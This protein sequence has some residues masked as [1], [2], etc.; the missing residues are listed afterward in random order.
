MRW[1]WQ[2]KP[3]APDDA[4]E[5]LAAAVARDPEIRDLT[6]RLEARRRENRFALMIEEALRTHR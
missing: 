3:K 2:P 1:P 4:E 6:D 5:K